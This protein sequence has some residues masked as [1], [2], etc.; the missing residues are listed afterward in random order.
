MIKKWVNF[1]E[2]RKYNGLKPLYFLISNQLPRN[3]P[4]LRLLDSQKLIL[5]KFKMKTKTIT[6]QSMWIKPKRNGAFL[7]NLIRPKS[8]EK[9]HYRNGQILKW[10]WG[11]TMKW[12]DRMFGHL[13]R[14]RSQILQR[15]L[16]QLT[17][18]D[19]PH[20]KMET[21]PPFLNTGIVK[22][23]SVLLEY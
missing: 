18:R 4:R 8:Q 16:V 17:S 5:N 1:R 22:L 15:K 9:L 23:K 12:I 14:I 19:K 21:S 7:I 10:L 20:G 13:M 11:T 6:R 3:H 2:L